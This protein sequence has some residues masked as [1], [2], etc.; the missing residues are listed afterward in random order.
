MEECLQ[1]I[2]QQRFGYHERIKESAL[3][4]ICKA[5]KVDGT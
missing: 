3:S 2:R 5:F 4:S 1:N